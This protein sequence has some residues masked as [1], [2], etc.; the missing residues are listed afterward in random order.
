[1]KQQLPY[2]RTDRVAHQIQEILGEIATRYIDLSHLGFITFS[3]V[4]ITPDLKIASVY[5][6][7]MDPKMELKP[8]Q[9]EMKSMAALFRKHLGNA[10]QIKFTPELRFYYDETA[11]YSH[12]IESLLSKIDIPDETDDTE[13]L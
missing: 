12:R 4:A 3:S 13:S 10:L 5:Y 9:R 7:V 2:K 8:L 6:S 11:D 1:M